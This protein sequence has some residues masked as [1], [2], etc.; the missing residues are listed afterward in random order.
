MGQVCELD[1]AGFDEVL[2]GE[3]PV[4]V[5]FWATWCGPCKAVA[6]LLDELAAE[7]A[8]RL[9]VAKVD[10]DAEPQLAG[11]FSVMSIPTMLVMVG[12]QEAARLVGARSKDQIA[13]DVDRALRAAD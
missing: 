5:E 6:P 9:V 10:V 4:L 8:G 12:G 11:R 2:S 7:R 1:E 13:T 3:L